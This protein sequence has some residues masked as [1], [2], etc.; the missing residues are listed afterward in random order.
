M[1]QIKN[2]E[3]PAG[4]PPVRTF[5]IAADGFEEV[6]GLTVVDLLRR[7]GFVCDIVSLS[8]G[9]TVTG[10][11]GIRIGTDRRF[12]DILPDDYDAVILPG[13]FRGTEALK[14]DGRVLS[15]LQQMHAAG[16]L[17]AA[18]CA[19]PTVLAEAGILKGLRA[20]CYPGMEEKLNGALPCTDSVVR[21]GTVITSRGVGT[22]I[23]FALA[24]IAYLDS[25]EH[26]EEIA[27]RIVYT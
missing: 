24:V 21:D 9:E 27:R 7:A 25:R 22:S 20:T 23:A 3:A 1:K 11:H 4:A 14:A 15:L 10:S 16:K 12:S 2:T 5:L 26:A 19:A 13:G 6:E 18:V 8:D 17:T